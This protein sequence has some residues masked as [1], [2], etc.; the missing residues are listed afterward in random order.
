MLAETV[1][2]RRR[3]DECGAAAYRAAMVS[4]A[5]ARTKPFTADLSIFPRLASVIKA[6][7][8]MLPRQRGLNWVMRLTDEIYDARHAAL[9]A[10]QREDEF[11]YEEL[12]EEP[13]IAFPTF[14]LRHLK[15]KY[16]V[17]AL[18]RQSLLELLCGA[19]RLRGM[20][21]EVEILARFL[22]EYYGPRHL[23]FFL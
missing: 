18:T 23:R 22:E 3:R 9:L 11:G 1:E 17:A 12:R 4:A 14:V 5:R 8:G 15:E 13:A 6:S 21:P 7:V 2:I 20:D 10:A 16:G 19:Q